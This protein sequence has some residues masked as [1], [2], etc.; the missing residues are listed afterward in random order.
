M[1]TRSKKKRSWDTT[2]TLP[3]KS[4]RASSNDR[5]VSTSR[6]FEGSSVTTFSSYGLLHKALSRWHL[7]EKEKIAT[8]TKCLGQ[9]NSTTFAS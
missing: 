6:S 7:T 2:M 5:N 3:T 8:L 9:V 4:Q 1:H